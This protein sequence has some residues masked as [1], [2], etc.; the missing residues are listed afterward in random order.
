MSTAKPPSEVV[1][2]IYPT[3]CDMLGHLNHASMLALMERA[4]WA[5]FEPLMPASDMMRQPVFPVIRRVEIDYLAQTLPG[6]DVA[7]RSGIG[8]VGNTSY[9]IHQEART[10]AGGVVVARATLVIV[11]ID[12]A[13][14]PV[15]VPQSWV[16]AMPAWSS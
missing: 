5:A 16:D 11:A 7:I 8:K 12:R 9:T 3:D 14:T 10:L 4:R 15:P 6:E 13:G 2:H 1:F